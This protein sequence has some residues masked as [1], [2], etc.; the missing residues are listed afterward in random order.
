MENIPR[1]TVAG[2]FMGNNPVELT[3]GLFHKCSKV[4]EIEKV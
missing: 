3:L 1:C 2:L 4:N